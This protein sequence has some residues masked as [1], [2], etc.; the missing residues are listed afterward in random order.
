MWIDH[1][2]FTILLSLAFGTPKPVHFVR[3]VANSTRPIA[4]AASLKMKSPF[5][6]D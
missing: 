2:S 3:L 6:D 1:Q 4:L 5:S